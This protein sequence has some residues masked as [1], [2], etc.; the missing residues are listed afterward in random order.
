MNEATVADVMG[1]PIETVEPGTP[2]ADVRARMETETRRSVV[3][4]EAGRY[5]GVVRW[6]DLAP[7]AAGRAGDA[8]GRDVPTLRPGDDLSDARDRLG[9]IDLDL[10]PVVNERGMLVGEMPRERIVRRHAAVKE[11]TAE[12]ATTAGEDREHVVRL[13]AGMA[14]VDAAGDKIGSVERVL[15]DAHGRITHLRLQRGLLGKPH[16]RLPV[17]LVASVAADT[18]TLSVGKEDVARLPDDAG[19]DADA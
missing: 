13:A 16:T 1:P 7:G 19:D 9:D 8:I 18:V 11:A 12:V 15:T 2:L 14:V 6:R 5:L 17:D 3:V 10:V 4:A